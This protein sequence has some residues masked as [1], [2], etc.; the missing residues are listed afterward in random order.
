MLSKLFA[1]KGKSKGGADSQTKALQQIEVL[2][3]KIEE[4]DKK[5][6]F[7]E[8]QAKGIENQAK[9]ALK[10]GNKKQAKQ[11]LLKKKK[12]NEQIKQQETV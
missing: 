8:K 11:L 6:D 3:K 1:K 2:N 7:L 5:I 4:L 12:I 9:E 10:S